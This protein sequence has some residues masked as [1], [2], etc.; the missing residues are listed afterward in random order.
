MI[1]DNKL[2]QYYERCEKM[3]KP[4]TAE[5][6]LTDYCNL[7][8]NYCR[9]AHNT[10]K[11]MQFNDFVAYSTRLVQMGVRGIIL[12]GGGEPTINPHFDKITGWLERNEIPYGINTN[13]V[14]EVFCKANFVKVSID[15]GDKERYKAIRGKDKLDDVLNHLRD[16]IEYKKRC[17][18]DMKI[19]VQCVASFNLS[20]V[21]SF[22]NAVKWM[23]VDYIYIRPIESQNRKGISIDE[24]KKV[25]PAEDKRIVYS[26]KFNLVDYQPS[27]CVANWSV[28]TVDVDVNVPYCCHRPTDIVGHVLD[29][30]IMDKKK[31]HHVD[32]RECEKPCRLSGANNFLESISYERDID[33]I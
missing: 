12:T 24:I 2:A 17:G 4:I 27:W 22:Y 29:I 5:I 14:N 15:A 30:N 33:F 32:M 26:F 7:N 8:C 23:D 16:L 31:S 3:D 28:I 21:E 9:Y 13:L 18:I 19:G 25:L 1:R 10:G 6:F 11:W 20:D